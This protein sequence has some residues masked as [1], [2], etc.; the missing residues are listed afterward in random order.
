MCRFWEKRGPFKG[1]DFRRI[2]EGPENTMLHG[3]SK[4]VL[5]NIGGRVIPFDNIILTGPKSRHGRRSEKSRRHIKK[6]GRTKDYENKDT[7]KARKTMTAPTTKYKRI[8]LDHVNAFL[9]IVAVN[10]GH[11]VR[12]V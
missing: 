9:I 7:T 6:S 11:M 2:H 1:T 10:E 3:R 8:A 5:T 12:V 4:K